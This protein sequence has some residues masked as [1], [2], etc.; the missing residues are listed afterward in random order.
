MTAQEEI[1][2]LQKQ[3]GDLKKKL[4]ELRRAQT[5][6]P[7]EDFEFQSSTGNV[8]LSELFGDQKDLILISNMGDD[9]PYCTLWADGLTGLLPEL[10]TRSAVALVTPD[11]IA[12]GEGFAKKRGWKFKVI[13]DNGDF[14]RQLDFTLE[15]GWPYPGAFGFHKNSDGSVVEISRTPFGPGD[16]FCAAWPLIDLLKDGENGWEPNY[17]L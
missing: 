12:Q 15:S 13:S 9:C 5:P 14:R 11:P 4:T 3:I 8:R 2:S 17:R 10:Q 16:D 1:K 7:V 6:T